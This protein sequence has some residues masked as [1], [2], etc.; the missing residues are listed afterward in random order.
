MLT[1]AVLLIFGV[2]VTWF[3]L[4]FA[5][6]SAP[7]VALLGLALAGW[8]ARNENWSVFSWGFSLFSFASFMFVW[9]GGMKDR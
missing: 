6:W 2:P 7:P 5:K 9:G 1:L 3:A 8:G 4:L